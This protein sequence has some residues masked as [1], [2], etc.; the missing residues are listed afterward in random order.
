MTLVAKLLLG[1]L[2]GFAL[3]GLGMWGILVGKTLGAT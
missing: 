1:L 2:V 3:M